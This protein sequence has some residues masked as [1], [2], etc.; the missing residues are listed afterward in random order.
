[1]TW[2]PEKIKPLI[3]F[4]KKEHPA[5]PYRCVFDPQWIRKSMSNNDYT[6]DVMTSDNGDIISTTMCYHDKEMKISTINLL[7]SRSKSNVKQLQEQRIIET[8]RRRGSRIIYMEIPEHDTILMRR[9]THMNMISFGKFTKKLEIE[10]QWAN[11][12]PHA[13]HFIK[14]HHIIAVDERIIDHVSVILNGT[15]FARYRMIKKGL[16]TSRIRTIVPLIRMK[17][18]TIDHDNDLVT[19]RINNNNDDLLTFKYNKQLKIITEGRF[20]TRDPSSVNFFV[21]FMKDF[22]ANHVEIVIPPNLMF[23]NILIHHNFE[24][25][26]FVPM[27]L[28]GN[29]A[30]IFTTRKARQRFI[31]R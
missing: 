2:N 25:S 15:K 12:V 6:W 28:N 11:F 13:L 30:L 27:F 21:I 16:D 19:L 17:K 29:D 23:Q 20:K 10:N 24:F 18:F 4:L 9:M 5:Y 22:N 3:A 26:A 8:A 1:M 31:A 14:N 7:L